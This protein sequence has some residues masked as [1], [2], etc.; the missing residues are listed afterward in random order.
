MHLL[1]MLHTH[2][3]SHSSKVLPPSSP[4]PDSEITNDLCLTSFLKHSLACPP[5]LPPALLTP[6]N[7]HIYPSHLF[8]PSLFRLSSFEAERMNAIRASCHYRV[9][10]ARQSPSQRPEDHRP[11]ASTRTHAHVDPK[12][13]TVPSIPLPPQPP[14]CLPLFFPFIFHVNWL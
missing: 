1:L 10:P 3:P 4:N 6:L 14:P 8:P 9:R 13:I 11:L 5:S 7:P 2:T 12:E